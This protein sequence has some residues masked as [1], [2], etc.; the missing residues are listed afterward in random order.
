MKTKIKANTTFKY[1]KKKEVGLGWLSI[2]LLF[3]VA[4]DIGFKKN[5]ENIT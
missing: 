2:S 3:D 5:F 1:K 4:I